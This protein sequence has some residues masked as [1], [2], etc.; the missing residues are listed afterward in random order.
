M[1][2]GYDDHTTEEIKSR[3]GIVDVIG[4]C[5]QLKRA[6]SN[7]KGVCPFHNEKTPSFVVSET[8]GIFTCFGCGATGDVIE[9]VKRYYN[10][11][12]QGAIEKLAGEYGIEIKRHSSP[13]ESRR[14]I[15]YEV[16]REAAAFFYRNFTQKA[17]HGYDYMSARGIEAPTLRKFGIGYADGDW[18]SLLRFLTAKGIDPQLMLEV[19]LISESKGRQFDKFRE[20]VIFPIINTR[21]KVIGFG[22]RA[23][24][25]GTPKYLNSPE[26]AVFLKKNNLYG[27]N[28]TRQDI[29]K[30]DCAILVEGY[31]DV[32]SLYQGGVRNVTASL[33]TA[34]TENQAAM[35][36]RYTENVVLCYDADA[37]GQA[38][39][40]RGMDILHTAGCKVKVFHVSDG[41][42]PDEFI[43][44]N[45]KE[46]FQELV[47]KALPFAEYKIQLL[48]ERLDVDTTEGSVQFLQETA[49][50]LRTLSPVEADIYIQKIAKE[51]RISEGAIRME[52]YGG[53]NPYEAHTA[54]AGQASRGMEFSGRSERNA[55]VPQ[56]MSAPGQQNFSEG[57][58]EPLEKNLIRLMLYKS[59]YVPKI[60]SYEDA[61]QSETAIRIYEL[62]KALYRDDEEIDV[63]KIADGLEPEDNLVLDDILENVCLADQDEKMFSDCI[64]RIEEVKRHKREKEIILQ[65]SILDDETEDES[66]RENI[67]SLTRELMEI[68]RAN[69]LK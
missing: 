16:N 43:K 20:R 3:C 55:A 22:G 32:I 13:A 2:S 10:L 11:D 21:G 36:K 24:G 17:N 39:A 19:G 47:R 1:A 67:A 61:F 45:G 6:G 56:R 59:V 34:L 53:S 38:A 64:S 62:I 41:K 35:L 49:K 14:N 51:T 5:V 33:G 8:K 58:I 42:D 44:A 30:E 50:I 54:F 28:L 52:V 9:F 26:S 31:M 29:N 66:T 4:R 18:N 68:Q 12:F 37:A 7:Y 57:K 40:L 60:R 65:L 25:D 27:L 48:R 23:I 15:L 46:A 63:K 69:A